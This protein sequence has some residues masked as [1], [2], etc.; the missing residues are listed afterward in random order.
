MPKTA[1]VMSLTAGAMSTS[2]RIDPSSIRCAARPDLHRAALRL[3]PDI[4]AQGVMCFGRFECRDEHRPQR[5]GVLGCRSSIRSGCASTWARPV[6]R[7]SGSRIQAFDVFV[8]ARRGWRPWCRTARAPWRGCSPP[9]A[10]LGGRGWLPPSPFRQSARPLPTPACGWTARPVR[11]GSGPGS[12]TA[13]LHI[14]RS[15]TNEVALRQI[16]SLGGRW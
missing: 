1:A 3:G 7:R 4:F 2:A 9:P 12:A 8:A 5:G 15:T 13:P 11:V 16:F 14:R 6:V 10:D